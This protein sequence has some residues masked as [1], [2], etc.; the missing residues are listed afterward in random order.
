MLYRS[1]RTADRLGIARSIRRDQ[2][3]DLVDRDQSLDDL[4]GAAGFALIVVF[5]RFELARLRPD[6][7]AAF[8][9]HGVDT[10]VDALL[11]LH[12]LVGNACR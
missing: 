5:D 8:G 9:V 7:H 4:N 6:L 12:A 10:H 11:L 3:I 2:E 1:A